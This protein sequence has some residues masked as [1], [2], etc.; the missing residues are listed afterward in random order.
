M[1]QTTIRLDVR[2]DIRN[3]REPFGKIMQT[4]AGLKDREQ[5]LLI[6]PFEPAP[7]YAVLAQ[8]GFSH[9]AKPTPNGDWEVLFTRGPGEPAIADT[10]PAVT[11]PPQ[12]SKPRACS[13]PP[14]LEVDARGLEPPQPLV[15]ILEALATLPEG[16][17]LRALTD[18][19]PMHLYAQLEERGFVGESEEHKDGSFITN[20]RRR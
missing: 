12:G 19:R 8:Q 18:R 14:M 17:R 2:E 3:G 9:Q 15:T 16:A 11:K 5:L 13:G 6:A 4:V 7:L 10:T 20:V 1:S